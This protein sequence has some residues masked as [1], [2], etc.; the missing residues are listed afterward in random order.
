MAIP[1]ICLT[2]F[3]T[4][5]CQVDETAILLPYKPFYALNKEVLHE[6]DK[7]GESYTAVSKNFQGFCSQCLMD[8]MYVSIL[9]G[10]NSP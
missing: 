10:Y 4:T 5:I 2:K 8:K 3:L 6:P 7:L 9:V 1:C